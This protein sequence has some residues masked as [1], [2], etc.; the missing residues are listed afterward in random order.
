MCLKCLAS[1][2]ICRVS[3]S[4]PE[5]GGRPPF[6]REENESWHI[7]VTLWVQDPFDLISKA[8]L[9]RCVLAC[10]HV[11][12]AKSPAMTKFLPG[13]IVLGSVGDFFVPLLFWGILE[14]PL[15]AEATTPWGLKLTQSHTSSLSSRSE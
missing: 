10:P 12:I 2:F 11:A 8:D 6:C 15:A 1:H 3:L 4:F 5:V 7:L 13:T 14:R 9:S